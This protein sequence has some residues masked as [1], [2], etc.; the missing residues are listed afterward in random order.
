MSEGVWSAS[1]DVGDVSWNVPTVNFTTATFVPGTAPHTWQSAACAGT[2]IGRKGMLVAARTL[3]LSVL[4]LLEKP[5]EIEAAKADFEKRK[6]G[7]SWV[8]RIA[9]DAKPPLDNPA[10]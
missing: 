9:S 3:A 6:A 7:R 10:K 4:E 5:Q 1:T 2:S 8:T